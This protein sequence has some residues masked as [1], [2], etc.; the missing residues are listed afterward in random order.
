MSSFSPERIHI[1]R[2]LLAWH[3]QFMGLS[4][5]PVE[6]QVIHE[7]LDNCAELILR[8]ATTLSFPVSAINV[9]IDSMEKIPWENCI[10]HMSH[11][12]AYSVPFIVGYANNH[13]CIDRVQSHLSD[14][15]AEASAVANVLMNYD[16][17]PQAKEARKRFR[18]LPKLLP[19]ANKSVLYKAGQRLLDIK[20]HITDLPTRPPSII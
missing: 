17:N 18:I 19:P 12:I 10:S 16:I 6:F 2:R 4:K 9:D 15:L 5:A 3:F 11:D 1:L 13:A 20:L 14:L 8:A 7:G